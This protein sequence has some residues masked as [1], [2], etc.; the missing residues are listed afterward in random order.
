MIKYWIHIIRVGDDM[1][2]GSEGYSMH[3][4]ATVLR[5]MEL[6]DLM[7]G[8]FD[9]LV[10]R[11]HACFSAFNS[12]AQQFPRKAT[13]MHNQWSVSLY[14]NK[15]VVTLLLLQSARAQRNIR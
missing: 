6:N 1:H 5:A 7:G 11:Y 10:L 15:F 9:F 14:E 3:K 2:E 4:K 12:A 8:V 13:G